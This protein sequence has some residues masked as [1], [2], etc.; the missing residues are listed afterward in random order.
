MQECAHAHVI[1][2]LGPDTRCP[3]QALFKIA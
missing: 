1:P 3:K 2:R